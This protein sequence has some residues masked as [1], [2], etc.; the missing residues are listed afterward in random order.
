M[1]FLPLLAEV[2]LN[3]SMCNHTLTIADAIKNIEVQHHTLQ[4]KK[5]KVMIAIGATDLRNNR[6]L[7]DI[8]REFT[9]LF[10]LCDK[11]GLKPLITTILCIDSPEL[12]AKADIF[13]KFLTDSFEN[14][15]DM[16]A[17]LRCGL[18]DVMTS[19]NKK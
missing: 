9:A 11:Y 14:V 7:Y 5:R 18:A 12:K 10:L 6:K 19:L 16:R 15:I 8:K 17:V 4:N 3:L 1:Y 13:N 2:K